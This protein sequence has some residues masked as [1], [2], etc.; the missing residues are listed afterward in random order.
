MANLTP[1][2]IYWYTP[3][4]SNK[5]TKTE[6]FQFT[7]CFNLFILE[8]K[9]WKTYIPG[10]VLEGQT[11][12]TFTA[13]IWILSWLLLFVTP[14]LPARLPPGR[15]WALVAVSLVNN[16]RS[17]RMSVM[18]RMTRPSIWAASLTSERN[19]IWSLQQQKKFNCMKYSA[20]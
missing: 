4:T 13:I 10:I 2:N 7:L 15:I 18:M 19:D 3:R 20:I 9:L 5:P 16:L 8:T 14:S 6:Q 17:V 11:G 1:Q 12:L